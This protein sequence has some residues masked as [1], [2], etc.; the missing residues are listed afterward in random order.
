MKEWQHNFGMC[1]QTAIQFVR[2]KLQRTDS[3]TV[4]LPAVFTICL[5]SLLA[6][7]FCRF[8]RNANDPQGEVVLNDIDRPNF[9]ETSLSC[10]ELL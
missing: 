10:I 9:T 7:L 6:F 3:S 8:H 1:S 5:H 4:E 2:N